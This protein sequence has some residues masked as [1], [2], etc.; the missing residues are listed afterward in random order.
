MNEA[1]LE[2][3]FWKG[4][5]LCDLWEKEAKEALLIQMKIYWT[6]LKDRKIFR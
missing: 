5:R 4:K 3:T 2:N 1:T 6:F